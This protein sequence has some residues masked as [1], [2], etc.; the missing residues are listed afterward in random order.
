MKPWITSF[1]AAVAVLAVSPTSAQETG[2]ANG[3]VF[4]DWTLVCRAEAVNQTACGLVQRVTAGEQNLFVAEIGLNRVD[5]DGEARVLM[6]LQ[7]PSA[8]LLPARPAY[9]VVGT[10][11]V[12]AL[13]WRTCAGDFCSAT[14]L[15]TDEEVTVMRGGESMIV[16]YQP[17]NSAD[18]INFPGSLVGVTAGLRALELE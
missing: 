4:D 11:D 3:T 17:I 1:L 8:M 14:R 16:G 2:A 15:L 7:T 9:Q 18:P 13:D 10:E 6:V 12:N 5:V